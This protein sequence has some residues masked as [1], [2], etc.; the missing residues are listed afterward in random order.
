MTLVTIKA[1]FICICMVESG[2]NPAAFNQR[3]QAVG[4]AQITPICFKEVQRLCPGWRAM[5]H[6]D[7]FEPRI[8]L[9]LFIAYCR[10]KGATT[11]EECVKLWNPRAKCEYRTRVLNLFKEQ[12]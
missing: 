6:D 3:E 7:C 11:P 4:C 1:L 12:L 5:K 2:N 9:A 8:S 10:K